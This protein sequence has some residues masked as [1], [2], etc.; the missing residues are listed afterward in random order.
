MEVYILCTIWNESRTPPPRPTSTS[1]TYEKKASKHS[2]VLVLSAWQ[3][4]GSFW[5]FK[6]H[7]EGV[8]LAQLGLSEGELHRQPEFIH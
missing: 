7:N 5:H 4:G 6:L 8:M 1:Y 3:I 2:V